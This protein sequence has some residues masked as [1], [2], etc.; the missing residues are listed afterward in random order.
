MYS[1]KVREDLI[2]ILYRLKVKLGKSMTEIVDEILRPEVLKLHSEVVME[3]TVFYD[4][5]EPA[6]REG[7]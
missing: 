6:R 4:Y 1:P 5:D 7:T 3:E 2:P